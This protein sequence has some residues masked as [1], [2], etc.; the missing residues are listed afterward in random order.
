MARKGGLGKGL[1]SLIPETIKTSQPEK[2]RIV[3]KVVEKIVEKPVEL[4]VK[5]SKVGPNKEQPRKQFDEDALVELSDSIRQFGIIQPL[6]VQEKNGFYEIIAGERRWR[7]AKLAGLKEV[8]VIVKKYT[9]IEVVEIS[10]IENIQRE[11]LN[12]IEEAVAYKRLLEEFHLKQDEVAERVSKSRTTVTNSM[13][14][15]KLDERVQQ[16]VIDDM[17]TTGH[18]RALLGIEDPELQAT[19]A[20]RVFDEKLSVREVEKIVKDIQKGK[21]EKKKE[22]VVQD[23]IYTDLEE[24]MKAVIG[25]KVSINQKPK[26]N[27]KIEIEYYSKDDL[28][29]II[30]LIL[31]VSHT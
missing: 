4:K 26:G 18:A 24:K 29:R 10:L 15:L 16:M 17:L 14:L 28:E 27:G 20:A 11:S 2:E 21:T 25:S 19:T 3:E 7:A 22:T 30:D 8:P 23:F 6:I 9:D 13:R 12:P 1:D 5:I 31:N